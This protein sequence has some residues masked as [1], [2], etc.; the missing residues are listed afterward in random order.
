MYVTYKILA[1]E[2]LN[3]FKKLGSYCDSHL[4]VVKSHSHI[5]IQVKVCN[6]SRT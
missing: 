1:Y 3:S 4:K 6:I 2:Y 5:S